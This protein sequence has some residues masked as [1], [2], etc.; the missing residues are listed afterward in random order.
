MRSLRLKRIHVNQHVIRRNVREGADEPPI[1]VKVGR[2]NIAAHRVEIDGASE[3]VYRPEKPL[4]CGARLWIE[5]RAP[6]VVEA[7]A[8]K[9]PVA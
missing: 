8:E 7:F 1:R 5:T 9:K 4:S 2:E 6:L 3:L